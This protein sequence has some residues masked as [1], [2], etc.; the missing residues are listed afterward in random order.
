MAKY[1]RYLSAW[2]ARGNTFRDYVDA[3]DMYA[4]A[5]RDSDVPYLCWMFESYATP[6]LSRGVAKVNICFNSAS[7]NPPPEVVPGMPED[8][9]GE[10]IAFVFEF[11][12]IAHYRALSVAERRRYYLDRI[13]GA[14][15]R[16][17]EHFGWDHGPLDDARARILREDFRFTFFWKK[18]LASP[19]RRAKV[20]AYFEV[21]DQTRI[22]LIFF[23]RNMV[24]QRR[25]R[26]CRL[27]VG[28]ATGEMELHRIEW[29]D[30]RTVRI[31]QKNGRD[32]WL[33]T[34]DGEPEFHYPRGESGDRHG[35]YD[36]GQIYLAGQ[37]VPEDRE[38]G[39]KLIESA[40]A[41]GY[42]HAVRFLERLA[43]SQA[44]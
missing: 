15:C 17:A 36:L 38:R 27:G 2:F 37:W 35:E 13:H 43:D 4:A 1:L 18:P 33:C 7:T 20:Q 8:K 30:S 23:D 44:S 26:L 25:V 31:T 14:L 16:C 39:L 29:L 21:T 42:T 32:Y 34:T 19:D 41:K 24:E 3:P 6:L 40:A 11:F 28:S 5:V 9:D 10:G 12:D 22:D